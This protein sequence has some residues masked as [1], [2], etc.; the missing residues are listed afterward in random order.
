[1]SGYTGSRG[2]K[3]GGSDNTESR[4]RRGKPETTFPNFKV[5]TLNYFQRS[6][7]EAKMAFFVSCI[8]HM[9]FLHVSSNKFHVS[10][11][12]MGISFRV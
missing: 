3:D 12:G 5:Q 1:M 8:T 2:R 10:L 6:E 4:G 9:Y 7:P 11:Y